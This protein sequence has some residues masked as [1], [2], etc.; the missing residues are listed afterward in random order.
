MTIGS[1]MKVESIGAFCNTFD[2]HLTIIGLENH[3]S[4]GFT[5]FVIFIYTV[6]IVHDSIA[7]H[8]FIIEL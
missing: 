1:L 7:G 8:L 6:R 5:I 2:L 4:V 3:F